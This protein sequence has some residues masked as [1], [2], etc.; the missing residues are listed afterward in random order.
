MR[1]TAAPRAPRA[2]ESAR[3]SVRRPRH[4]RPALHRARRNAL[5]R[6]PALPG[7]MEPPRRG[8]ST[9][10]IGPDRPPTSRRDGIAPRK[11]RDQRNR[12]N[13]A[14]HV[15]RRAGLRGCREAGAVGFVRARTGRRHRARPPLANPPPGSRQPSYTTSPHSRVPSTPPARAGGFNP[16][17]AKNWLL[18]SGETFPPSRTSRIGTLPKRCGARHHPGGRWCDVRRSGGPRP[19]RSER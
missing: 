6:Q 17:P 1:L 10:R 13:D 15:P 8:R 16:R 7:P 9:R 3:A 5:S 14:R 12:R 19:S 4:R 18:R 11:T 2:T